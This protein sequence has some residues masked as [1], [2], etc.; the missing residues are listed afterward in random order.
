[1]KK[2]PNKFLS[3]P[4][5]LLGLRST[6]DDIIG[7]VNWLIADFN[8][9]HQENPAENKEKPENSS[10]TPVQQLKSKI[11]EFIADCED[12]KTVDKTVT[13]DFMLNRLRQLSDI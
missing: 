6:Q 7:R 2:L 9:R 10:A 1:M 4:L 8:E 13:I 12:R 5:S 11:A 3:D